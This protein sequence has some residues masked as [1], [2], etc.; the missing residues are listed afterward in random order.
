MCDAI[1]K[2]DKGR[3]VDARH[4]RAT[5]AL[6]DREEELVAGYPEMGYAGLVSVAARSQEDLDEQSEV[7][8]Q[9]AR[10]TGMDLRL[11]EGRQD[12]AWAASLPAGIAPAIGWAS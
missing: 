9:L 11:L 2:E 7:V 6:L 8:E 5:Q 12:L 1:T 3:R 4:R 10:E